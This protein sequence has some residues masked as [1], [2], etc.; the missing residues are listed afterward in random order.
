MSLSNENDEMYVGEDFYE[1]NDVAID[2]SFLKE[3][4]VPLITKESPYKRT[5]TEYRIS[6]LR[7]PKKIIDLAI[8]NLYNIQEKFGTRSFKQK[9]QDEVIFSCIWIAFHEVNKSLD[10]N[11][12]HEYLFGG[13]K[14]KTIN[15]KAIYKYLNDIEVSHYDFVPFYV[16]NYISNV[17]FEGY[18]ISK[19][20][21]IEMIQDINNMI[22][23]LHKLGEQNIECKNFIQ[24]N[25]V[26]NVVVGIITYYFTYVKNCISCKIWSKSCYLTPACIKK[27]RLMYQTF[28]KV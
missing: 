23:D 5:S 2:G 15:N 18:D 19:L 3:E 21:R 11:F 9:T 1:F 8:N 12:L 24:E 17:E 4:Y 14:K 26:K 6:K 13:N 27:Y 16:D 7:L 10:I 20:D 22:D 28:A 25:S